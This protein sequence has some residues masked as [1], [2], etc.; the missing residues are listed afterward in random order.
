VYN[1]AADGRLPWSEVRAIAGRPPLLLSPLLTGL[2]AAQ[3]S[4][5][6]VLNLPPETLDLLRFG[7]G[8]DNHKLKDAGFAYRF[9][10]AGAVRKFTEAERL[11]RVVGQTEPTYRYES[12][13]ESFFRHSPAVVRS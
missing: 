6:R 1:V 4:R 2:A 12:D 9:T 3:L 8:V 11:R 5:L 10:T 13:V 7:R